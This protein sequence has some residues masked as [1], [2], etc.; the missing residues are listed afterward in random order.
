MILTE[1]AEKGSVSD[2]KTIVV[3]AGKS[4]QYL[5]SMLIHDRHDIIAVDLSDDILDWLKGNYDIMTVHLLWHLE[6]CTV[7]LLLL[8]F[9]WRKY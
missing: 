3:G 2:M 9:F 1:G 7:L 5:T 8:P 6:I 4:G